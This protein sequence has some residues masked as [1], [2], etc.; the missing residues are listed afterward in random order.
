MEKSFKQFIAESN[1]VLSA[2]D[3]V[4]G[5]KSSFEKNFPNGWIKISYSNSGLSKV[6]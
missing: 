1:K 2:Q 6:I 4:N 5:I 3:L